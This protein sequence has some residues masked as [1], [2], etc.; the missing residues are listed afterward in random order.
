MG[1]AEPGSHLALFLCYEGSLKRVKVK[2]YIFNYGRKTD[3]RRKVTEMLQNTV[4]TGKLKNNTMTWTALPPM[5]METHCV[6]YVYFI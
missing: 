6:K 5:A 3:Y 2:G 4:N 1:L